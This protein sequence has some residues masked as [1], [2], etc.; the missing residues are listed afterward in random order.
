LPL[1]GVMSPF[2]SGVPLNPKPITI[3]WKSSL[4][5]GCQ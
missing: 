3:R 1:V 5:T 2:S 4:R